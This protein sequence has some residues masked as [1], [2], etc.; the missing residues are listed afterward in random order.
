M[1]VQGSTQTGWPHIRLH[2]WMLET[3]VKWLIPAA[4][5]LVIV[6]G[7]LLRIPR[8]GRLH[9]RVES[10]IPLCPVLWIEGVVGGFPLWNQSQLVLLWTTWANIR[11]RTHSILWP[12]S[13]SFMI[14]QVCEKYFWG[15]GWWAR[16]LDGLGNRDGVS[17]RRFSRL[18]LFAPSLSI[19][20]PHRSL[21]TDV[22]NRSMLFMW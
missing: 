16:L 13:T 6:R 22:V 3:Q 14:D 8:F 10:I 9:R 5:Q 1:Q 20:F 19:W 11:F 7:G 15:D 2:C 17:K 21:P 18:R 4:P 12:I